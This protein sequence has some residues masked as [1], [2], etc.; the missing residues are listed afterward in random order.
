M[1]KPSLLWRDA[2]RVRICMQ[3]RRLLAVEKYR[4]E[5]KAFRKNHFR[6]SRDQRFSSI[7]T[8]YYGVC[9]KEHGENERERLS[10]VRRRT[11][12]LINSILRFCV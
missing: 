1:K 10:S 12:M 4:D 2:R 9:R 8:D 6:F 3:R 11:E 5:R 7:L